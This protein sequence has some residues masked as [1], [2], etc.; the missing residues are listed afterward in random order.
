MKQ[1]ECC[2]I[3]WIH[4]EQMPADEL[5]KDVTED[6]HEYSLLPRRTGLW[7]LRRDPRAPPPRRTKLL[8]QEQEREKEQEREDEA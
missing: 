4:S 6:S 8:E 2:E 5:T 7:T 1:V 3:R